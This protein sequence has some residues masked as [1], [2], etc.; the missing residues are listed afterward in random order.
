[1]TQIIIINTS[2]IKEAYASVFEHLAVLILPRCSGKENF[3]EMIT[4]KLSFIKD[5]QEL[6][7]RNREY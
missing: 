3:T 2:I 6:R 1:M 7:K 4:F 5:E